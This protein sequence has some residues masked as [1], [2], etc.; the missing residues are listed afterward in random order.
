[1]MRNRP[2]VEFP[3]LN[4]PTRHVDDNVYCSNGVIPGTIAT[5]SI[6]LSLNALKYKY[7]RGKIVRQSE[8]SSDRVSSSYQDCYH[9][10]HHVPGSY[11]VTNYRITSTVS[12]LGCESFNVRLQLVI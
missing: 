1:M 6:I 12:T 10:C 3:I 5:R 9:Y 8:Q 2:S 11:K 7:A 4:L